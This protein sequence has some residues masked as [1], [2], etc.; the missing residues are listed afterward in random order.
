MKLAILSTRLNPTMAETV[1]RLRASNITVDLI[2][3]DINLTELTG[4]RPA[5]DLYYLKT[6]SEPL[7]SLAGALHAAGAETLNAYP[8]VALLSNKVVA[9]VA[10]RR[11]GLPVPETWVASEGSKLTHLLDAGPLILKPYR[12]SRG[13][14]VRVVHHPRELQLLTDVTVLAQRYHPGDGWDLKVYC[15]GDRVLGLRRP[16]PCT[17]WDE[18]LRQSEP[19]EPDERLRNLALRC[20]RTLGLGLYGLD[21]VLS[22]GETWVV[23]V[24]KC[25]GFL[26]VRGAPSLLCD[27]LATACEQAHARSTA[28]PDR[29]VA[30]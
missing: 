10:L 6:A 11:A 4:L 12:G 3:P 15:I 8:S 23:D 21:V 17:D 9:A 1:E 30:P 25:A 7:L 16:W 2:G 27:Y 19:F 18:K 20:G 28:R 29:D 14:G 13:R 22:R 24:N 26:G 5:H